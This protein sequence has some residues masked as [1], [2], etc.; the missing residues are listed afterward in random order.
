MSESP[1]L[2]ALLVDPSLFTAP[3]DAALTQGLLQAGVESTWAVRPMRATERAVLP[4]AC[5]EA[6]FYGWIERRGQIRGKLRTVAKGISHAWGLVRLVRRA[7]ELRP[8]V[9][10]FQWVVV[11]PLDSAAMLLL[12][13]FCPLVLTVHDT[14]PYNGDRMS[15]LQRWGFDLPLRLSDRI[16]VHTRAGHAALLARGT[17]ESKLRIVPHGALQLAESPSDAAL[18]VSR[19]GLYRFVLFGELKSYKGLDVLVE[20]L[21]LVPAELLRK[22]RVIIAGRP[23]MPLEP[24][25]ARV[26][27]LGLNDTLEIRPQR[28]SEQEMANLFAEADCFLFPYRQI[29]ASGVYFL[30]KSLGKWLIASKVGIFAEELRE[31]EQGQLVPVGDAAALARAM[32]SAVE[33]R[34]APRPAPPGTDWTEIGHA[35]RELYRDAQASRGPARSPEAARILP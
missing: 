10:H 33:K 2:R 8:D 5:S 23:R 32:S 28:Q 19:D 22:L 17:P 20:A 9:V 15:L 34:P 27:E 29:D 16:I 14:V 3:Y 35:T 7:L 12:R 21:A 6:L 18:A 24:L 11:P 1:T 25:L 31:A 13:L 30:V 26:A 4:P